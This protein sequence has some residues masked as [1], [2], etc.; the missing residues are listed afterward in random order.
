VERVPSTRLV[1]R[2]AR[3]LPGRGVCKNNACGNRGE[4]NALHL[5][6]TRNPRNS[7]SAATAARSESRAARARDDA[8]FFFSFA[9]GLR[10][11]V[12]DDFRAASSG[13]AV[14]SR[15]RLDGGV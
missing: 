4:G 5:A 3:V 9:L 12:A 13:S 2:R 11:D 10:I 1:A 7:A 6:H 15:T 14:V 8:Q